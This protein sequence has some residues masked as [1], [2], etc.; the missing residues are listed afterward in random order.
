MALDQYLQPDLPISATKHAALDCTLVLI[1]IM[2]EQQ[3]LI[4][5][6]RDM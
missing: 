5:I 3:Y 2:I 1:I 4:L 6:L